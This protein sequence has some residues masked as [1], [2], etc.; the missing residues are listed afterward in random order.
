MKVKNPDTDKSKNEQVKKGLK[1]H[2]DIS[3]INNI[4]YGLHPSF[5][6]LGWVGGN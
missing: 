1:L 5:L 2:F 4:R 3:S 6:N